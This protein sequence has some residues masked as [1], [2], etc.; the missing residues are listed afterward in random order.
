MEIQTSNKKVNEIHDVREIMEM[1]FEE[2]VKFV[3]DVITT[4]PKGRDGISLQFPYDLRGSLEM[5]SKDSSVWHKWTAFLNGKGNLCHVI[6][7]ESEILIRVKFTYP[8]KHLSPARQL[9]MIR[10][11]I[12][13]WIV[14]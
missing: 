12:K 2:F 4:T 10:G 11:K 8:I 1:S 14:I 3:D 7:P 5:K 9:E 13:N 6:S